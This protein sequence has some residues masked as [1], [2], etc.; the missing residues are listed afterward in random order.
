[1]LKPLEITTAAIIERLKISG[2]F[3]DTVRQVIRQQIIKDTAKAK[4]IEV[5]DSE[6]QQ[7]ADDFRVKYNLYN[8]NETWR[9][10]Q[11]NCLTGDEFEQLIYE[12][13]LTPKLIQHLLGDRVEA[14]FYEHQLDYQKAVLYEV[15]FDN[16]DTAI[17]LYY[18]LQ[19][20][21]I[22]FSQVARKYIV[23][24]DL[25]RLH[26]YKGLL[27]RSELNSAISPTVF[28]AKPPQIIKPITVN[29]NTHLI[30]VEEIIEPQL[31]DSIRSQILN[32]LFSD[33]LE[34]QLRLYAIEITPLSK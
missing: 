24:P 1:M 18:A 7:A 34:K 22:G 23:E 27:S 3:T 17:E 29:G 16:F 5:T 26:G 21:E 19:E 12:S 13:I 4:G 15:V 33:W 20:N 32:K 28:A 10:L 9:W 11:N 2:Q 14:Y 8:S 25:R 31:S 30:L 6:L